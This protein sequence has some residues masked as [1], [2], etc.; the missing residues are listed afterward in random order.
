M[1]LATA[2]ILGRDHRVVLCDRDPG[3]LDRAE[4]EL[5]ELGVDCETATCDITDRVAVEALAERAGSLGRVASVV[6]TAGLSPHMGPA[7]QILEVNALGTVHVERAFRRLDGEGFCI[8]NVASAAG[9]LPPLVPPSARTYELALTDPDRFLRRMRGRCDLLPRRLRPGMA[10]AL[11]KHFV[12]WFS[13]RLAP[14]LGREGARV[15]SVSPGSF[16]TE[17][18]RLEDAGGAGELA[19]RS[20]L[21]RYGRVEEIAELLAFVAGDRAGYLTGTDILVDGGARAAMTFRDT[22]AMARRR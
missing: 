3:R 2:R 16:D 19:R 9:H 10:Y 13:R 8:V 21:G 18:G 4:L 12:I 6:H 14:E 22:L 15:L 5:R 17:M 1:G 7:E 11:S 20:A